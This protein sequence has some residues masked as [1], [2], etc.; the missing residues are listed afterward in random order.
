M[1]SPELRGKA[2][3]GGP[4]GGSPGHRPA[5][6]DRL[7]GLTVDAARLPETPESYRRLIDFCR[8]WELNALLFRLT[9]DQGAALR[10]RSHPELITHPHALTPEEARDLARYGAEQGVMLI[11]EVESF[12]HTRYITAAPRY[13]HLADRDPRGEGEFNGLIPVDPESLSLMGDLYR[14]V[15]GLF[16]SP[17]L[18]GGCD[19]VNWGGSE[20]SRRAL[21]AKSRAQIWADYLNSLDEICRRLGK[22][23]IVWGDFVLHKEREILPR[24][25]KRVIVMD[26]Q[27]Y[28]TEPEPLAQAASQAIG[29]GLRVIGAPAIISCEWGPRVGEL[30]L[31]NL[32]AFARAY[33]GV[34][35]PR[36]LGVIVTNWVPSRYLQGSLWDTFAYAAEAL[37]HGGP[38]AREPAWKAFGERFYGA[39][40]DANWKE[41]FETYYRITPNRHS[42]APNWQGPRLPVPWAS[43]ADLRTVLTADAAEAPP[44]TELRSRILAAEGSVRR[45]W[46]D[47]TSFA[48]SAEYLDYAFWRGRV[49]REAAQAPDSRSAALL[50]GTIAERDRRLVDRLDAEWNIGRFSDSPGKVQALFDMN[51]PDQLLFRM[52]QAA[53]FSASLAGGGGRFRRLLAKGSRS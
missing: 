18:H 14:E 28:V 37:R 42:C 7:R 15:A 38:A 19:E 45:N 12:G 32:D 11:P 4:R 53:D 10:F 47:F 2:A 13:A 24:L 23:L 52:R 34:S 5:A 49:V 33:A 1:K 40:W 17:Y 48:L 46:Q 3:R 31:R 44:F 21:Q 9:D 35:D 16:P 8:E 30:Q 27:Y 22:E 26:W 20:I 51:P 50:I 41:V 36:C 6:P 25:S 29:Q 43:E 39:T